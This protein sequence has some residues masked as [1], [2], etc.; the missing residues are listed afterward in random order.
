MQNSFKE[1][2]TPVYVCVK[3]KEMEKFNTY[4]INSF[5]YVETVGCEVL[6][7]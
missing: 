6:L 1:L 7:S 3:C 2:R 4:K 5:A